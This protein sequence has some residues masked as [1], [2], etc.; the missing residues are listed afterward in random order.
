MP[1][2]RQIQM[3]AGQGVHI[4]R[5][6]ACRWV[7]RAAWWLEGL[8]RLHISTI[9]SYGRMFCDETRMPVRK[10]GR[11]RTQ[12]CQFWTLAIDDRPWLG[13]APAAVAYI[14]AQ[15]RGACEIK[16]MLKTYQGVLQVDGYG[17]YKALARPGR[18]PGPITLVFCMAHARRKFTDL[19]KTTQSAFARDVIERI[20][21]IYA[22]EA[23]I[24]GTSPEHRRLVRQATTASMMAALKSELEQALVKVSKTSKL[25]IAIRYSLNHWSGL[26]LFLE[27]GRLEI[28]SNTVERSMRSVALGRRNSLFAGNDGGARSWA[29]LASLLQTAKLNGHDPHTY[30]NDVLERIVSGRVKTHELHQLLAWNWQPAPDLEA[31]AA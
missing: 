15:T 13:P 30:L 25:A 16:E 29:I 27:D 26:I 3:F 21:A 7:K 12:V 20:A 9:Q 11:K 24:R 28:D 1:L 5:S 2:N 18:V 14:F 8:Y 22:V 19:Y 4:D 17:A 10:P 31:V 23:R 6:T